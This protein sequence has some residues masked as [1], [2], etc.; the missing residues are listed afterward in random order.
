M[1]LGHDL[2]GAWGGY[3]EGYGFSP[4]DRGAGSGWT[5]DGGV[6]RRI[7]ANLQFDVEVGRGLTPDA[8]DWSVGFGF[9]IR[10]HLGPR[11]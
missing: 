6:S 11:R 9:A 2:F 1:S 7:G 10:E 4:M 3:I 8:A 5:L